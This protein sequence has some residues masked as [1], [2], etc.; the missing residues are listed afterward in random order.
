MVGRVMADEKKTV[1]H[2]G[3]LFVNLSLQPAYEDGELLLL[4]CQLEK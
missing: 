3:V 1:E 2:V 4:L